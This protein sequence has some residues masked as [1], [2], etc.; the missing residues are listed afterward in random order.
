MFIKNFY[1]GNR[2]LII[3]YKNGTHAVL[4]S[5]NDYDSVFTGYIESCYSFI[6]DLEQ[7]YYEELF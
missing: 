1:L 7:S 5:F 4:D 3:I 6:A 2:E